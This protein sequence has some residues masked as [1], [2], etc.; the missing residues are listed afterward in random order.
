MELTPTDIRIY[1]DP[2]GG[3]YTRCIDV[4]DTRYLQFRKLHFQYRTDTGLKNY[5][6]L[7]DGISVTTVQ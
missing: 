3:G 4:P 5:Y 7:I 1:T 6:M 2:G